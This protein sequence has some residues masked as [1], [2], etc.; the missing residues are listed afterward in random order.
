L[1]WCGIVPVVPP[2]PEQSEDSP[3]TELLVP[4]PVSRRLPAKLID[5]TA[6]VVAVAVAVAVVGSMLAGGSSD[7]WGDLGRALAMI[8]AGA[9]VVMIAVLAVIV[10]PTAAGGASLGKRLTGIRVV[11]ISGG[12]AGWW[13]TIAREA[14]LPVAYLIV[15]MVLDEL[16][17]T[18]SPR[19]RFLG[20]DLPMLVGA[21]L[22]LGDLLFGCRPDGRTGHDLIAGTMVT[23]SAPRRR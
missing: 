16:A 6:V 10:V 21:F 17:S 5:L 20:S 2:A 3:D 12:R 19:S 1:S 4:A 22:L 11:S 23:G 9:V 14:V 15:V 7:K 13:R 18:A 8:L